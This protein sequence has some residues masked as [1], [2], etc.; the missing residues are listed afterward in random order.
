MPNN[1]QV[2]KDV[3]YDI[4]VSQLAVLFNTLM[5]INYPIRRGET[6]VANEVAEAARRLFGKKDIH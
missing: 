3:N 5:A 1:R 4:L 2:K 6:I